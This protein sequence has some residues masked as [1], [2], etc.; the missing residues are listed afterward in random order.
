[1]HMLECEHPY[2]GAF[3][4]RLA[5]ALPLTSHGVT[6]GP[7]LSMP[8]KNS[9][10]FIGLVNSS[11]LLNYWRS[12]K[13]WGLPFF[14]SSPSLPAARRALFP[15]HGVLAWCKSLRHSWLRV[16]VSFPHCWRRIIFLASPPNHAACVSIRIPTV[17]E[18]HRR[19]EG[20]VISQT[21]P[22]LRFTAISS[23][24]QTHNYYCS[25][26]NIYLVSVW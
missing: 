11:A 7:V 26:G 1:M 25:L 21:P 2:V 14:I 20:T 23:R 22:L 18:E 3:V 17:Y 5:W 9:L 16:T 4:C 13:G 24:L 10:L 6:T 19:G 15:V 12:G 8:T